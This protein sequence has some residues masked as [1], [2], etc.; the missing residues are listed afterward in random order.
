VR[1]IIASFVLVLSTSAW[2]WSYGLD[3]LDESNTTTWMQTLS[4][5][6][7]G[8]RWSSSVDLRYERSRIG[9][10]SERHE[11]NF[12]FMGEGARR[13]GNGFDA[14][15]VMSVSD[16]SSSGRRIQTARTTGEFRWR[17]SRWFTVVPF[18]GGEV[19]RR[20]Y[21]ANRRTALA[22]IAG[23]TLSA[24]ERLSDGR[25]EL[26]GRAHAQAVEYSSTPEYNAGARTSFVGD[27]GSRWWV[28][29]S[30]GADWSQ[31]DYLSDDISDEY[32]NRYAKTSAS[33]RALVRRGVGLGFIGSV[34]AAYELSSEDYSAQTDTASARLDRQDR[35]LRKAVIAWLLS[36]VYPGVASTS[37]LYEYTEG[38]ENYGASSR[39]VEVRSGKVAVEASVRPFG[40]DSLGVHAELSATSY[41]PPDPRSTLRR[42][43]GFANVHASW[44][45]V[46]AP[47][48][49]VTTGLGYRRTHQVYLHEVTGG[50]SSVNETYVLVP[51]VGWTAIEGVSLTIGFPISANYVTYD[52]DDRETSS[53]NAVF[54]RG[55]LE[56]GV[57]TKVSERLTV[58]GEYRHRREDYGGL[59]WRDGWTERILWDRYTD[60]GTARFTYSPHRSWHITGGYSY[61]ESW[62]WTHAAGEDDP[63]IDLRILTETLV[64]KTSRFGLVYDPEAPVSIS[65]DISRQVQTRTNTKRRISDRFSVT[66]T[67]VF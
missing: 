50:N 34:E 20:C 33:T 1:A 57:T 6:R 16:Q 18:A 45:H 36:R 41:D 63:G 67:L 51:T 30:A 40:G 61:E 4:D 25:A 29:A 15:L 53:R 44:L 26:T 48:L 12:Y 23:V 31:Q 58:V 11:E 7:E 49:S 19:D 52:L 64:R 5:E 54:R 62:Q 60:R 22:S 59:V 35:D 21:G 47:R 13:I 56:A 32:V 14:A 24:I 42:D 43:V 39:D 66:G 9:G 10:V 65:T 28:E 46:F 2:A 37:V 38:E 55:A 3:L 8:A 27:V 17:V